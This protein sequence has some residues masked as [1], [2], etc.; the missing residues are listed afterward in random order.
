[1]RLSFGSGGFSQVNYRQNLALIE[2][3]CEWA[4]LTGREKVLDIY[5]GNGNFSLPLAGN[6]AE[7]VGVEDYEPSIAI[8]RQNAAANG[9]KNISFICKDAATFIER[10]VSAGEKFDVVLLDPPRSGAAEVVRNIPA[11]G[12]RAILY[13]S[14]DPSTLARDIGILKKSG[15]DVVKCR[16]I[17]MFPQTYH[18]E[19]VTLLAATG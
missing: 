12:P 3:V 19:S 7:V 8:A 18:I 6:V 14:C 5:C 1:L 13:V 11:L 16:P 9:L 2:T 4:A 15:Y 10:A 17:D